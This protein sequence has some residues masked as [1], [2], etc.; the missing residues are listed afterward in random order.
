V[1]LLFGLRRFGLFVS[2]AW[3]V[4]CGVGVGFGLVFAFRVD[5]EWFACGIW[6][7]CFIVFGL[8]FGCSGLFGLVM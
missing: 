8:G 2:F 7:L 6:L 3:F 1:D 5:L 4:S